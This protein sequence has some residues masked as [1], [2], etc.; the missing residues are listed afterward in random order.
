MARFKHHVLLDARLGLGLSQEELAAALGTDVRTLRRYESGEV[1]AGGFQVKQARRRELLHRMGVELGLAESD[2]VEEELVERAGHTLVQARH[3]VGRD[4]LVDELASSADRVVTIVAVGGA[5]KTSLLAAVAARRD[6]FVWSFYDDARTERLLEAALAAFAEEAPPARGEQLDRLLGA[7]A[8]HDALL[9]LDGLERVQSPG[10][11]GALRGSVEDAALRRLLRA[12]AGG[13]GGTRALVASRLPLADLQPLD[14]VRTIALPALE[15]APAAALLRGWGVSGDDDVLAKIAAAVGGHALSLAAV[16]SYLGTFAAGDAR[17]FA[18]LDLAAAAEDD[19]LAQRLERI[20]AAYDAVLS[21]TERDL[22]AAV[23]AFDEGADFTLLEAVARAAGSDVDAGGLERA[24]RRLERLGLVAVHAGSRCSA[25]PFVRRP[26][27]ARLPVAPELIHALQR[28]LVNERLDEEGAR[29]VD[30]LEQLI[31]H[32]AGAGDA[33][34]AARI[35]FDELGGFDRLG[36]ERGDMIRGERITRALADAAL[37]PAAKRAL[38]YDAGLYASALGDLDGAL[39]RY[40]DH[41]AL[42]TRDAERSM[43]LRTSAYTTWLRGDLTR[44]LELVDA[45]LACADRP[46]HVVRAVALRGAL[47]HDMGEIDAALDELA[48]ARA[49]GDAPVARRALWEAEAQLLRGDHDA[50]RAATRENLAAC[51]ELRWHGHAAH[52]H[53]VLGALALLAGDDVGA[54]TDHLDRA[55]RW[56]AITGEVD[57]VLRTWDLATRIA[58][59]RGEPAELPARQGL[60][61]ADSCGFA[62]AAMRFANWLTRAALAADDLPIAVARATQALERHR[63]PADRYAWGWADALHLAGLAHARAGDTAAAVHHLSAA[64]S[65]EERLG[66]PAAEETRAALAA[67]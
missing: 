67:N 57:M 18:A 48:R 11:D 15:E 56:T 32:T 21:P 61:L 26:W 38:A 50:A 34:A 16:A 49:R 6:C 47:L 3:F 27:R 13:L 64:L 45:A 66:S 2:L 39:R 40:A 54:A 51:E 60:L 28:R 29:D 53:T 9:V 1:N 65:L 8:R 44:A 17:R 20:F 33:D 19:A 12:V 30:A 46:F 35:Y 55:R 59:A 4:A 43:G 62:L 22:L 37:A 58:L 23:S 25:H 7:L 24:A 14:G 36:L 42:A 41:D 52:C 5:G 10:G 31:H 63:A